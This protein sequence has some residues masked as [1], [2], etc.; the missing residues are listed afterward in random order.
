M[1]Y[2][3][4]SSKVYS[5]GYP[6]WHAHFHICNNYTTCNPQ[7]SFR[8][9]SGC[10]RPNCDPPDWSSDL[11]YQDYLEW[12][13]RSDIFGPISISRPSQ[14]HIWHVL[15]VVPRRE[16]RVEERGESD[17]YIGLSHSL[18]HDYKKDG[19]GWFRQPTRHHVQ[20]NMFLRRILRWI[21][22]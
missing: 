1:C 13:S 12:A 20:R 18:Q 9:Y 15:E 16:G 3:R 14:D 7:I 17:R 4:V 2:V 8:G 5:H 6:F 21:L 22:T 19:R 10:C 11:D